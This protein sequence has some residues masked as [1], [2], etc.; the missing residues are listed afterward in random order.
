MKGVQSLTFNNE[1]LKEA[2]E[3]YLNKELFK[4]KVEVTKIDIHQKY[5][6]EARIE[7]KESEPSTGE[8][9]G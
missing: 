6:I 8:I 9:N 2:I 5:Q 7:F 1:S 3:Y 4:E